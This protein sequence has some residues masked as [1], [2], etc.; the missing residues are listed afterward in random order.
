MFDVLKR[1]SL[2]LF[3]VIPFFCF[4]QKSTTYDVKDSGSKFSKKCEDYLEVYKKLPKEVRYGVEIV[5]GVIFFYIPNDQFFNLIFDKNSDGIARDQYKCDAATVFTKSSMNRGF[6]MPP[7]YRKE[8]IENTLYSEFGHVIV[9]YGM[10]PSNFD[11]SNIECNL[12]VLQKKYLCSYHAFTNL[13][14][15]DWRLLEMGLYRDSLTLDELNQVQREISKTISVIV[16]FE[17]NSAELDNLKI[18]PLYDS[19]RLTDYNIKAINISSYT[20]VEGSRERNL[21]LQEGR[22]KSIVKALQEFQRP[23]IISRIEVSE[24]WVEFFKDIENT[25]FSYLEQLSKEQIKE[26]LN[27]TKLVED[28]EPILKNHRKAI[29]ELKLLKKFSE[30][31]NDPL[32]LKRFF[33]QSIENQDIQQALYI[34]SIIFEKLGDDQLPQDFIGQLEVPQESLFGQL[35]NNFAIYNFESNDLFIEEN[36]EN[37]E[38]LLEILPD[39]V[40]INYNLTVLQLKAMS[41][42]DEEEHHADV[43]KSIERLEKM[44]VDKSLVKRLWVNY[45]ILMTQ[46]FQLKKDYARKDKSLKEVFWLYS[47]L[48]WDDSELLRLAKYMANYSKYDWAEKVLEKRVREL[49]ADKDLVFYYLKL[50]MS[51]KNKTRHQ[52]Y[53]QFMLNAVEKD[54]KRFCD[55]FLP[56]AQGGYT[57]QLLDDPYLRKTYCENCNNQFID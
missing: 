5:D 3:L 50:T 14:F 40:K 32:L 16:P 36:I 17:K 24:N 1:M 2:L 49:D 12:L 33:D 23:E 28:L 54:T 15:S 45:H 57:F 29:I 22:S 6:L 37:F 53:R 51:N 38:K 7:M 39:N 20:S 21:T 18:R 27:K 44:G 56:T 30:E 34:Q 46:Y 43:K 8:M 19:L 11:A 25:K 52:A 42:D 26:A 47:K 41:K 9:R 4:S 31:E 35:L 55:M 13:D 48:K 10:L